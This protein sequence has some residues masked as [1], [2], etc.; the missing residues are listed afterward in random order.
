VW[1]PKLP[2]YFEDYLSAVIYETIFGG[3]KS[4]EYLFVVIKVSC[5]LFI[6]NK[7]PEY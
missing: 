6:T 3:N 5:I 7:S 2:D 1:C 4:V